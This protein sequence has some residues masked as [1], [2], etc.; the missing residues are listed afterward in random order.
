[1]PQQRPNRAEVD[2]E[3]AKRLRSKPPQGGVTTVTGGGSEKDRQATEDKAKLT[4]DLSS[5]KAA[6]GGGA[7]MPVQEQGEDP[8]AY[9]ERLRKWR[10]SKAGN[11]AKALGG[12]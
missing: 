9:G 3:S 5:G 10:A 6:K 12:N 2:E 4:G 11:Q 7:G 1:M 8:A